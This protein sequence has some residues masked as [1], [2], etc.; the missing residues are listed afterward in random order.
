MKQKKL[1]I[2]LT[3]SIDVDD[4][5]EHNFSSCF[6]AWEDERTADEIIYD[7]RADRVSNREIEDF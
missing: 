5:N 6:G 2:K 7:L 3:Q 4:K 1:I